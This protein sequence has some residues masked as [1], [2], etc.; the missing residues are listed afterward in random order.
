MGTAEAK[1]ASLTAF[2]ADP[3]VN[4]PIILLIVLG[5]IGFLTW[6]DMITHKHRLRKYSLQ[7][8]LVLVTT[9]LLILLPA[10]YFFFLEFSALPLGE[11]ILASL[12]QAVTPR[13]AGFNTVSLGSISGAGSAIIVLLMLIG[14]SSGSTA[15]GMKTTTF[16][17][18]VADM[19]SVFRRKKDAECF[20]RRLPHDIVKQ[21]ATVL[22][23]YLSLFFLG[24]IIIS[25]A[26]GLPIGT[27]LYEAASA[28]GT[29]GLTLGTTPTLGIISRIVLILLMFFGR[30]GGLTVIYATVTSQKNTASKYPEERITVG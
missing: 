4:L 27:A 22:M 23:L 3:W 25:T 10:L 7:S 18:L 11:R 24:A 1:Y 13:T 16:A 8:K 5:G 30:V 2:V 19:L 28:V 26:E 9:G 6:R 12:F 17:V 21:A 20:G 15:G 14:G 29:V